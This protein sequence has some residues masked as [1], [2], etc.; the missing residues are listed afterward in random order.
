MPKVGQRVV[1]TAEQSKL[2][3]KSGKVVE[4]N[5]ASRNNRP[6][7]VEFKGGVTRRF[8]SGDV[9]KTSQVQWV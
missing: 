9:Y 3:G 6:Y 4:A 8:R 5:T 7:V 1:I 2:Y